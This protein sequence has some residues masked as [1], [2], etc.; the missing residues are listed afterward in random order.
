MARMAKVEKKS[1][2]KGGATHKPAPNGGEARSIPDAQSKMPADQKIAPLES[3]KFDP[4]KAKMPKTLKG[5]RQTDP[6]RR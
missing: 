4:I 5:G 2:P 3:G 6:F 1:V